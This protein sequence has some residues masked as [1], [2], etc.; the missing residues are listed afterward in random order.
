LFG[1]KGQQVA[2]VVNQ[3]NKLNPNLKPQEVLDL[4]DDI[5]KTERGLFNSEAGLKFLDELKTK[6]EASAARLR[7]EQNRV[8]SDLPN[9]GVDEAVTK[10]FRPN[11][12]ENIEILKKTV[13]P[14]V[15]SQVQRVSMNKLLKKSIDLNGQGKIT[16]VFKPGNLK[17]ALDSYGDETLDA[18]FGPEVTRG[19]RQLQKTMDVLTAGEA[20][21][22]GAAGTLVAAGIAV[23]ALNIGMLPTVAGLAVMRNIFSRPSVIALMTKTDKGSIAKLIQAFERAARQEG[24][25]LIADEYANVGAAV[26]RE[27]ERG[28]ESLEESGILDQLQ[29]QG[30]EAFN[31]AQIQGQQLQNQARQ[32]RTSQVDFPE[33]QPV[34]QFG[35]LAPERIEFAERIAGRPIV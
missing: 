20:G 15:F 12:Q 34:Q 13:S 1:N 8:I 23:N 32:I 9:I 22:G 5:T 3:I 28:Q 27:V 19:L 25:R 26:G 30:E 29:K 33:I 17:N 11:S 35:G 10:L 18:M 2:D 31:Q 14:E 6:A 21:R 7:F 4:V 24:V 16:D